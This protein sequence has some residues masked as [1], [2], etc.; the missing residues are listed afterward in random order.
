MACAVA[1]S[2][3]LQAYDAHHYSTA[4]GW[5]NFREQTRQIGRVSG[6]A[7]ADRTQKSA[8]DA[9]LSAA[10]WTDNDYSMV[11]G[12][13]FQNQNLFSVERMR[14]FADVAPSTPIMRR[15][16]LLRA[17]L[18]LPQS[19]AWI[20]PVLCFAAVLL[21]WS[22][23]GLA[24]AIVSMLSSL[25]VLAVI[26]VVFKLGFE[27][28]LWP[29]YAVTCLAGAGAVLGLGPYRRLPR[30]GYLA[31]EDRI[32]GTAI[33]IP[34]FFLAWAQA[35]A[36]FT[37]GAAA[38]E[39]RRRVDR[40]VAAW[41]LQANSAVVV[42]DHNFP[43]ETWVRPFHPASP[44]FQRFLH[45]NALSI[46]PLAKSFYAEWNTSDVAW[47]ICHVPG[48]YR[49]DARLGYAGPHAKMLKTYMSEHF[50]EDIET[51]TVFEGEALSLYRCRA[52]PAGR[53]GK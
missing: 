43:Y 3:L 21:R 12:W 2:L 33:L 24:I 32:I 41:P 46:T 15:L 31:I 36:A 7:F 11:S 50:Q 4:P 20:V 29:I 34:V 42:W 44:M 22:I 10:Q 6:Y 40:D 26:A 48:V 39:L 19:L 51:E 1:G 52:S 18:T 45:T 35:S 25:L 23:A 14:R 9:A 17:Q 8:W 37:R 53:A 49:V 38:E 16:D 5:E 28:I 30:G 27:H 13:L 47:A